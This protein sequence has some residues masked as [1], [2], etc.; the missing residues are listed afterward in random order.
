MTGL[1][2][3]WQ[4]VRIGAIKNDVEIQAEASRRFLELEKGW[5]RNPRTLSMM[6]EECLYF[7]AS[8]RL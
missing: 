4:T 7:T 3:S 8:V 1:G 6:G 2:V 5:S